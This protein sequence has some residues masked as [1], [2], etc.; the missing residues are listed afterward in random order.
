MKLLDER[1]QIKQVAARWRAQYSRG[2]FASDDD[3]Q[4]IQRQLDALDTD[5]AT[6]DDVEVIIGNG[7]WVEPEECGECRDV[8]WNIVELGDDAENA[9]K[10]L[11]VCFLCLCRAV[12]L[13]S[14]Q[15][16]LNDLKA[17]QDE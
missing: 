13:V 8:T 9:D 1:T 11:P 17:L 3:K 14:P 15:L 2:I 16:D 7:S 6:T 5:N 10:R 12:T 4:Q